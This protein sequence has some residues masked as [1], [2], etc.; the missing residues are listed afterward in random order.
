MLAILQTLRFVVPNVL[1]ARA[2][3]VTKIILEREDYSQIALARFMAEAAE[4]HAG[5]VLV[6]KG[7][8]LIPEF[9]NDIHAW[10]NTWYVWGGWIIAS[11]AV[12]GWTTL[13]IKDAGRLSSALEQVETG[14]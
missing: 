2:W 14:L 13:L 9:P 7:F 3:V 10:M 1:F 12:W 5:P 6:I 4:D 8:G 11:A